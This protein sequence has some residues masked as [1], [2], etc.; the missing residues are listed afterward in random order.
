MKPSVVAMPG[1]ERLARELVAHLD[2]D[3]GAVMVRHFP[4]AE[5]HVRIEAR[6]SGFT[7]GRPFKD[8]C[9]VATRFP[10]R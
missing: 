5:S 10:I 1:N 9:S 2:L 8:R 3:H 7:Q 4:D 6:T